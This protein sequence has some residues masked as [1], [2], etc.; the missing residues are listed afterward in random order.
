[1]LLDKKMCS[2]LPLSFSTV[3]VQDEVNLIKRLNLKPCFYIRHFATSFSEGPP[4]IRE[5]FS[6]PYL[7]SPDI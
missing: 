5:T 4:D 6:P 1:M 7:K 2:R 3:K